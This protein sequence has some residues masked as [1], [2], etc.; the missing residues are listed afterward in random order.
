MAYLEKSWKSCWAYRVASSK[1]TEPVHSSSELKK[2]VGLRLQMRTLMLVPCIVASSRVGPT[3]SLH[4]G[5][6]YEGV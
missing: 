2:K 4:Q 3:M 5:A 1:T 6:V